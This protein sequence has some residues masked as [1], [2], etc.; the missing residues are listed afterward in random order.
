MILIGV[1]GEICS[2]KSTICNYLEKT[3]KYPVFYSDDVAKYL[4]NNDL[5]LK[6]SIVSYFGEESYLNNVYNTKYISNIVF[7]DVNKLQ[8]LNDLFKPKIQKEWGEFCKNKPIAFVESAIIFE[9]NLQSAF[10]YIICTCC[11]T[12]TIK[13]RLKKRNN[14]TDEEIESRLKNQLDP[15]IKIANSDYLINTEVKNWEKITGE[16]IDEIKKINNL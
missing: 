15:Q 7:N 9:T 2:G 8:I 5:E 6:T 1:T 12:D 11:A 10:D 3:L 4:A 13:Q 16:T 14:Y